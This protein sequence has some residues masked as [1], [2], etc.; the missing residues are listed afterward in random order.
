MLAYEYSSTSPLSKPSPVYRGH[1]CPFCQAYLRTLQSLSPSITALNGKTLTITSEPTSFLAETR[2]LTGYTGTT[3]VDPTN[4]LVQLVKERYALE[5]AVSEQKGY[6]HGMAQPG[7]LVLRGGKTEGGKEGEVLEKWAIVPSTMNLGGAKDRPD[8]EQ[9][10]DNVKA[11]IE[12]KGVVHAVYKKSG[13]L[14]ML[15]GKVF[16]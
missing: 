8:L 5:I 14:G 9:V 15:W 3:I 2:K 10:W 16:G 13:L 1:W 7:I 6:E 12:G 11:K 4:T